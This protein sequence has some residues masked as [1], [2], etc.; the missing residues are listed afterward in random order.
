MKN[1]C[2]FLIILILIG[3]A[4]CTYN[5]QPGA[6]VEVFEEVVIIPPVEPAPELAIEFVPEPPQT[7]DEPSQPQTD[8]EILTN[9]VQRICDVRGV[10]PYFDDINDVELRVILQQYFNAYGWDWE[11]TDVFSDG[12]EQHHYS[13]E[14]TEQL[15]NR[16][17]FGAVL[18]VSP[19]RLE[20]FMQEYFNP[21][22]SIESYDYKASL[23]ETP[24]TMWD[25]E[26]ELIVGFVFGGGLHMGRT[27]H[28]TEI[29]EENGIYNVYALKTEWSEGIFFIDMEYIRCTFTRNANGNFNIISKQLVPENEYPE[30][31]SEFCGFINKI[32]NDVD[33]AYE[34]I[35]EF[36]L[37]DEMNKMRE[38]SDCLDSPRNVCDGCIANTATWV[39]FHEAFQMFKN[40]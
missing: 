38:C 24:I 8:E 17:Y 3:T 16:A 23:T 22:F 27:A 37:F 31:V 19:A 13:Y 9:F 35:V 29:Y 7:V 10:M 4:S 26:R 11:N 28:I 21:T 34:C 33:A 6:E 32:S 25:S 14:E 39:I 15:I 40:N 20:A 5:Q 2:G 36:N 1:I 30:W 12:A 18:G